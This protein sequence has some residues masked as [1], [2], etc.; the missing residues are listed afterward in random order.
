MPVSSSRYIDLR[1]LLVKISVKLLSVSLSSGT[2]ATRPEN[3][4][5]Y[6]SSEVVDFFSF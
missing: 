1:A 5:V 2:L 4:L 3:L 6:A